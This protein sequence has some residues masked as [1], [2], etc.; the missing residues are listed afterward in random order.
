MDYRARREVNPQLCRL[1]WSESDGLP[2]VIVDRYGEYL[3]LQTLTLG[4]DLRKELIVQA[5]RNVLPNECSIIIERNDAPV[6]KAEGLDPV[7]QDRRPGV[8]HQVPPR[9]RQK[10]ITTATNVPKIHSISA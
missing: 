1:I 8:I 2:G 10:K 9:K 7:I 3:V 5:I 6:R 4:M